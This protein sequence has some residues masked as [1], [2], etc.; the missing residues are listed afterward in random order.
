MHDGTYACAAVLNGCAS[1]SAYTSIVVLDAPQTPVIT[2]EAEVCVG[3]TLFLFAAGTTGS[4]FLWSTPSGP[5]SGSQLLIPDVTAEDGGA[6]LCHAVLGNCAGDTAIWLTRI[7]ICDV[8]D[9]GTGTPNV[10]TP[11]GDGVNDVFPFAGPGFKQAE[12]R[13][14]NRWGQQVAVV[15]GRN[16]SWDGRN[17]SSGELLSEG[18]YF[19]IIEAVTTSGESF[20]KAGY[21]HLLR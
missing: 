13:V 11:N 21:V 9:P 16:A 20:H 14:F 7:I 3:D 1:D 18:V 12:L 4:V 15:P 17:S 6:Y 19:Y 5:Y 8:T 10:I 2:G